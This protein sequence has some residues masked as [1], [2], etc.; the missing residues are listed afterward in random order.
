MSEIENNVPNPELKDLKEQ[1]ASLSSLVS[2]LL[3]ALTVISLTL[4]AFIGLQSRRA[5]KDVKAIRPRATQIIEVFQKQQP[6]IK[7]FVTQLAAYG[8]THPD[9]APIMKKYNLAEVTNAAAPNTPATP[10]T[11]PAIPTTPK[12]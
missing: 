5:G 9:F 10:T 11:M 4:T 6:V 8:K 3:V 2:T 1:C 12:K 7:K